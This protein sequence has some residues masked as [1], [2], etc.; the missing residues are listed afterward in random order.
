MRLARNILL[1][2]LA[3]LVQATFSQR[4]SIYGV[5]PDFAMLVLIF[6]ASCS[7]RTSVIF[8]GFFIGFLQDV[9]SPEYLGY[10][11]FVMSLMAFL[12]GIANERFSLENNAVKLLSIFIACLVHDVLYLTFY[13]QFDLS[14]ITTLFLREC[15]LGA[16]YTTLMAFVFV[17]LC[18]WAK[19]GGII[20][21]QEIL[22]CRR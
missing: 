21:V 14:I 3:L 10:N 11:T 15:L 2:A 6:L 9:Y 12:L 8:Y 19:N 5:R 1:I 13:T 7:G 17:K 4:M 16:V 20:I 18:S 22:G